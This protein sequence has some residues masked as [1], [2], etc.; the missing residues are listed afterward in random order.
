MYFCSQG[1]AQINNYVKLD[2][3]YFPSEAA[4]ASSHGKECTLQCCQCRYYSGNVNI[5]LPLDRIFTIPL[6]VGDLELLFTNI[7]PPT[8]KKL[9]GH[10]GFRLSVHLS[11]HACHIL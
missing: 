6:S 5:H 11:V 4:L 9:T 8:S 1:S 10:I 7:M 2:K 3:F